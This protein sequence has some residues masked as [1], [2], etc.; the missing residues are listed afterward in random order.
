MARRLT[1]KDAQTVLRILEIEHERE[2]F[3]ELVEIETR[4]AML[5]HGEA[6]DDAAR[7]KELL[8][9]PADKYLE[10]VGPVLE[11]A[12]QRP[13]PIVASDGESAMVQFV[14]PVDGIPATV[15]VKALLGRHW[16]L[17]VSDYDEFIRI[18]TMTELSTEQLQ[19]LDLSDYD[20]LVEASRPFV[21]SLWA[22]MASGGSSLPDSSQTEQGSPE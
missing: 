19:R 3:P 11:Q 1:G 8:D 10:Y 5:A 21:L 7:A 12:R 18:A 4:L 22:A 16:R 14:Y 15:T 6:P 9:L 13:T 2:D 17:A 20:A